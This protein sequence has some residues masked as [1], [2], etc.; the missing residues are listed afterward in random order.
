MARLS[1]SQKESLEKAVSHYQKNLAVGAEYLKGRGLSHAD[2]L[3]HRL[4]VVTDPFNGHEQYLG[5]LAI[6]YLT[7]AGVIDLRFRAMG[8]EQP[9]YLGLPGANTHLYNVNAFFRAADWIA[10]C[11]GEI[12]A[13]TLDSAMNYP[14][15]GVPG[16][17]NWKRHYGR[18]LQ[19][20]DKIY[21]FADGDQA[22][23]DFAKNLTKELGN[24]IT[25]HMPEVEDVNSTYV[26]FGKS[27]FD[28]KLKQDD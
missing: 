15:I 12:D 26:K 18:I 2:A 7:K 9:K 4:G 1:H 28:E 10:V 25:L 17:N 5:R 20:F 24:V 16:V 13:I 6:P 8:A 11:E 19:D 21:V 23:S 27:W 14:A 3:R 22:G